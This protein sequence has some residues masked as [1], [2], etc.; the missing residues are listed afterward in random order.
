ME[1]T[2]F[3]TATLGLLFFCLFVTMLFLIFILQ[4][5]YYQSRRTN[6]IK[7]IN[8]RYKSVK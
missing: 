1:E 8:E 3:V 4:E 6:F 7:Q 5:S 2:L